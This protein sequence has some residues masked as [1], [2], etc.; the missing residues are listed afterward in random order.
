MN[1]YAYLYSASYTR[2]NGVASSNILI[3]LQMYGR[4]VIKTAVGREGCSMLP[5]PTQQ[6]L[7]LIADRSQ[8]WH[9]IIVCF[10]CICTM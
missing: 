10:H 5:G 2:V 8:S 6:S 4:T 7:N 3:V 1:E 9:A